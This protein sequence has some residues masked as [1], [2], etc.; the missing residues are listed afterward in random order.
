LFVWF[1][2][3]FNAKISPGQIVF[4][5]AIENLGKE[6]TPMITVCDAVHNPLFTVT[7]YVPPCDTV[8]VGF[9]LPFC[10]K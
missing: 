4:L 5:P 6:S 9:V 2:I 3:T 7:E 8:S 1:D 10:H